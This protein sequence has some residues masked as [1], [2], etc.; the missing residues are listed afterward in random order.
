MGVAGGGS[1]GRRYMY[2]FSW[3]TLLYSRNQH[4][5]VKQLLWNLKKKRTCETDTTKHT[6][7]STSKRSQVRLTLRPKEVRL[8]LQQCHSTRPFWNSPFGNCF[9][10][11]V[12]FGS[13]NTKRIYLSPLWI[14]LVIHRLV[15]PSVLGKLA[16][17]INR[18]RQSHGI[19]SWMAWTKWPAFVPRMNSVCAGSLIT[20]NQ[21]RPTRGSHTCSC[22]VT[23]LCLTLYDAMDCSPPGS[24]VHGISQ[25]RILERIAIFFSGNLPDPRIEPES[26]TSPALTGRFFTTEPPGKSPSPPVIPIKTKE[27]FPSA[28]WIM[29]FYPF[30]VGEEAGGKLFVCP[31]WNTAYYIHKIIWCLL[32]EF[33]AQE[34]IL[35]REIPEC[36]EPV[37]MCVESPKRTSLWI[38][39]A[40]PSWN[41][42]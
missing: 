28:G 32:S 17:P 15:S 22:S 12:T 24:S 14:R 38:P 34:S 31:S 7:S 37:G 21:M 4:N 41:P 20:G 40:L 2:T 27:D 25:V 3:F 39:Y 5:I 29:P 19:V 16:V 36:P 9:K 13:A 35:Q 1:R 26:P 6:R 11:L 8:T 42:A 10:G 18:Y 30:L 33:R 23:Q